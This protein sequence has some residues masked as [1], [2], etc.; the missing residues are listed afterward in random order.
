M[1][2]YEQGPRR[3]TLLPSIFR[4]HHHLFP[5]FPQ[6]FY[7]LHQLI[8]VVLKRSPLLSHVLLPKPC[9]EGHSTKEEIT[10]DNRTTA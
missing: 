9:V 7:A 6:V 2:S 8:I 3:I 4:R 10:T 1:H 5:F